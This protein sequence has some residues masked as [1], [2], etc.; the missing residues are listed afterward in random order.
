[1]TAPLVVWQGYGLLEPMGLCSIINNLFSCSQ[2]TFQCQTDMPFL[3]KHQLAHVV[4]KHKQC[5][6]RPCHHHCYIAA[7]AAAV[8]LCVLVLQAA[9]GCVYMWHVVHV[10]CIRHLLQYCSCTAG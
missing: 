10:T 6:W 5:K 2:V 4:P 1:M 3:W 9:T 8:C 7:A